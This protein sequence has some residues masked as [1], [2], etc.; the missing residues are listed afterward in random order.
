MFVFEFEGGGGAGKG[1]SVA[2]MLHERRE[3]KDLADAVATVLLHDAEALGLDR[4]ADGVADE[5]QVRAGAH[6]R[7]RL[8]RVASAPSPRRR[9]NKN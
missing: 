3:V 6:G 2:E 4:V 7:D 9:H 8:R 1:V 5:R